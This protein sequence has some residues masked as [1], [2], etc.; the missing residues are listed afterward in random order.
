LQNA[1]E[2]AWPYTQQLFLSLPDDPALFEDSV[3]PDPREMLARWDARVVPFLGECAL[4]IPP[5]NRKEISRS[6]HTPHLKVLL[7]EMQ[8]VARSEPEAKW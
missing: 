8:A 1:L 5:E 7:S 2:Q 4:K 6:Q 3:I